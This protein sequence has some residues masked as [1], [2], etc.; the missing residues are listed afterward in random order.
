VTSSETTTPPSV[1]NLPNALTMLRLLL[2]PV[3]VVLLAQDTVAS[4]LAAAAVFVVAAI[5][6]HLDG[7]L[8]RSRNLITRFGTVADTVADKVLVI[9]ALVLLSWLA[10]VPWWVTALFTVRELG[11]TALKVLVVRGHVMPPS[12]GGKLKAVL[13]MVALPILIVDWREMFGSMV[14]GWFYGVGLVI[15]YVALVVAVATAIDYVAK[16]ARVVREPDRG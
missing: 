4:R 1:W 16:A 13:Q 2:V 3:M 7:R 8:A 5:T 9:A 14:G 6:D 12:R 15:L 11:I 10:E